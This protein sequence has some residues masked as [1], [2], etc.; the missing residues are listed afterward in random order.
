MA[1][2]DNVTVSVPAATAKAA[3]AA[4]AVAAVSENL[5]TVVETAQIAAVVPSK[6]VLNQRAI[7]AVS[8]VGGMALGAGLL[9]GVDKLREIK[10]RKDIEKA[11]AET[12]EE[13]V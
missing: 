11:V 1:P 12:T 3:K 8:V 6:V 2:T 4:A 10:R 5:P 13:T 7:V 9:Y